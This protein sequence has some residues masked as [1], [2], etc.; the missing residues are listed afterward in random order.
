MDIATLGLKVDADGALKTVRQFDGAMGGLGATAKRAALALGTAFA[1]GAIF[2]KVIDEAVM[3]QNA[4][5]QVEAVVKSTGGSANRSTDELLAM[6]VALENVST[7]GADAV[8]S[9]QALLLTFTQIKGDQFDAATQSTLNL[10]QAMG[11]DLKGAALQLGKA[12]N[13]PAVGITAL[14][15]SGVSFSAAQKQVIKDLVE[16]GRVA[17]AQTVIL[18]ELEVQFGGSAAAARDTLGGALTGLKNA[19]DGLFEPPRQSTEEFRGAIELLTTALIDLKTQLDDSGVIT[20]FARELGNIIRAVG[21]T[22]KVFGEYGQQIDATGDQLQGFADVFKGLTLGDLDIVRQGIDGNREAT[23]RYRASLERVNQLLDEGRR[24][25]QRSRRAPLSGEGAAFIGQLNGAQ[26]PTGPRAGGVSTGSGFD[27]LGFQVAE[28]SKSLKTV[29]TL[30]GETG[31]AVSDAFAKAAT[32]ANLAVERQK[33]L[34][35]AFGQGDEAIAE[36]TA[37]LDLKAKLAQ[38]DADFTGAQAAQLK[39]LATSLASAEKEQR[40]LNN[41]LA[42]AARQKDF[43]AIRAANAKVEADALA[44][45]N[46]ALKSLQERRAAGAQFAAREIELLDRQIALSNASGDAQRQLAESYLFADKQA[47][48]LAAGLDAVNAAIFA[49]AFVERSREVDGLTQS[50]TDWADALAQVAS[51]GAG[52]ASIFGDVGRQIGAALGQTA[53]LANSLKRARDAGKG[54]DADGNATNVGLGGALTG[55]A[56]L[57]GAVAAASGILGAV[58]AVVAVADA[59]DLFGNKAKA[60]AAELKKLADDFNNSLDAFALNL[61]FKGAGA[62]EQGREALAKEVGDLLRGAAEAVGL[63]VGPNVRATADSINAYIDSLEA[64]AAALKAGGFTRD[65]AE[66]FLKGLQLEQFAAELAKVAERAREAEAALKAQGEAE[67]KR[68]TDD[69][70]VRRLVAEGD[71]AGADALREQ[72]A[73]EQELNDA[74]RD[75]AGIEGALAY[76]EALEAVQ[77]AEK[78]AAEA[79]RQRINDLATRDFGIR[80]QATFDPVGA[81]SAEFYARQADEL[82]DAIESGLD[83]AAI[84]SLQF[85][86]ALE[87]IAF[88]AAKAEASLRVTEGLLSRALSATGNDRAA[89]AFAFNAGQRQELAD[90]ILAGFSPTQ[91]A[92]LEFTQFAER[93][94]FLLR[95]AI[96]DQTAVIREAADAQLAAIDQQIATARNVGAMEQKRFAEQIDAA[97][98]SGAAIQAAFQSQID[99]VRND[100]KAQTDA[101]DAQL[102]AA[103]DQAQAVR[104]ALQVAQKQLAVSEKA[105]DALKTFSDSL[106]TGQFSP[107]SPEAQLRETRSRFELLAGSAQGGDANAA[108]QL[109]QAARELLEASRG[110]NASG[111]GFVDDF[112]RVQQITTEL[113]SKFGSDADAQRLLVT[114]AEK[115]A[116][117]IDRTIEALQSQ[118]DTIQQTA[119]KQ[120]DVLTAQKDAAAE[121]SR[122]EIQTLQDF[123][124]AARAGNAELIEKLGLQR[125]AVVASAEEQIRLITEQLTQQTQARIEAHDF[126]TTFLEL[127]GQSLTQTA[128]TGAMQVEVAR[129]SLA[130][131]K[132]VVRELQT[133]F[134]ELAGEVESS[135]RSAAVG[136]A[137]VAARLD[138]AVTRLGEISNT[139]RLA[140]VPARR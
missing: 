100:A 102:N 127:T 53:Q 54:T 18:K 137:A 59:F 46:A 1:G 92:L 14:T 106:L 62:F 55:Q 5:A 57:S 103:R 3:A 36:L 45:V 31:E 24:N 51:A 47:E 61:Q 44:R 111:P 131:L 91:L 38:I 86:Q 67:L 11:G 122:L 120:I 136:T 89:E 78:A 84:A 30:A 50:T 101:L 22:S 68:R 99:A 72:L 16:T 118:K 98:A 26:A 132:N 25:E 88:E 37:A 108:A 129:D 96:E 63:Q 133:G 52:L 107:L 29:T 58:G 116:A 82:F 19:Y 60:R 104:A 56:G 95:R 35:A 2:R 27:L 85:A 134:R 49:A 126:Y 114:A 105:A 21:T 23:E 65:N 10:A 93:E 74:R 34:N 112:T 77:A 33:A 48:A 128:D 125:D 42:E 117:G 76:I 119:Q 80:A 121:S 94:Q 83:A 139:N 66:N 110:F 71:K 12:L 123:A 81:A 6:S 135:R 130:E 20:G 9:A 17:D 115:T 75:T 87:A 90:A 7:F 124:E 8:Q 138:K 39:A 73:R 97:R 13:D 140:A 15:R 79:I 70:A 32:T 113:A 64:Q 69:L 43:A 41:A 28:V 109:P 4:I 40:A